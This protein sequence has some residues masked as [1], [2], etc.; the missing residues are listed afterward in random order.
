MDDAGRPIEA[1]HFFRKLH[2]SVRIARVAN[3]RAGSTPIRDAAEVL[4]RAVR[5]ERAHAKALG[6]HHAFHIVGIDCLE[7]GAGEFRLAG[8]LVQSVGS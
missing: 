7:V 5:N 2:M 4:K 3:P 1:A 8:F 6:I